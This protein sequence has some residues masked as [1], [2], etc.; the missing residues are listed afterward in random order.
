MSLASHL[1]EPARVLALLMRH[2]RA[3]QSPGQAPDADAHASATDAA[4]DEDEAAAFVADLEALGPAFVKFGQVLSTRPDLIHPA[5]AAALER[6]QDTC[7]PI[8]FGTVR[9]VVEAELGARLSKLFADVEESPIGVASLAQVHRATMRDG[10]VV[11]IKVQRPRMEAEVQRNLEALETLARAAEG[12]SDSARRVGLQDWV[13]EL[14]RTLVAE[15]DYRQ[16]AE[17]LE[18]FGR[19]LSAED[20]LVVPAPLLHLCTRRV[21]VMDFVE[22]TKLT[23]I[24]GLVRTERDIA[25]LA[26]PL[27]RGFLDQVFVHGELH[28]DPHPG[29]LLLTPDN[30]LALFDLGM[31]AHV[32]PKLRDPLL[33]LLVAAVDG[34]GEAVAQ[35]CLAVSTRLESF[36]ETR[37]IREI[38]QAAARYAAR[39]GRRGGGEGELVLQVVA[40]A[41]GCGV[42]TPPELS[43]L[44]RALLN[45]EAVCQLLDPGFD[46]RPVVEGHL[47]GLVAERMR[48]GFSLQALGADLLELQSLVREAPAKLGHVLNL[49]A[50]NRLQLKLTGLEESRLLE[51]LQKIANRITAGL[52][53]AALIV[54]SAML[55]E[56]GRPRVFGLALAEVLFV[57][58]AGLGIALVGS[59]LWSDRRRGPRPG[60]RR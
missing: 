28:A 34:R 24:G 2:R 54:A 5:Y 16:E 21:L 29:N 44:G 56:S 36:D 9:E 20:G 1:I 41:T 58:A 47:Q 23:A 55:A 45:L 31:V 43:V 14:R 49:L 6:T 51:N 32:T 27:L 48:Q 22:G 11:A 30:R 46:P 17:N 57:V 37:F 4:V 3:L 52:V 40:I 38:G 7:S 50:D 42:R 8:D 33:K 18:R 60:E 10:R 26:P 35:E 12:L 53:T 39:S 25:A 15:L 13:A 59:A 19:H